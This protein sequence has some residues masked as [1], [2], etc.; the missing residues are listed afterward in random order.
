[1][2][3]LAL[4]EALV[5]DHGTAPNAVFDASFYVGRAGQRTDPGRAHVVMRLRTAQAMAASVC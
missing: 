3:G 1:M 4:T 2:R 5:H